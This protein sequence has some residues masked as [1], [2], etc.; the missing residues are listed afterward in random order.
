MSHSFHS[1]HLTCVEKMKTYW[2]ISFLQIVAFFRNIC[3]RLRKV[4][5]KIVTSNEVS[6][7][8]GLKI[9]V[10]LSIGKW[11]LLLILK[12][13]IFSKVL[14]MSLCSPLKFSTCDIYHTFC[15]I[16]VD[17]HYIKFIYILRKFYTVRSFDYRWNNKFDYVLIQKKYMFYTWKL[18]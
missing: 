4:I 17:L 15:A 18:T 1:S 16:L 6:T 2:V 14:Y 8:V 9:I 7:P 3:A 12:I 5:L 13:L 11:I 10:S